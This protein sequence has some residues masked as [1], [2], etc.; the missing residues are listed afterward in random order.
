MGSTLSTKG[1]L[2]IPKEVREA[3]Q[4]A[5]GHEFEFEVRDEGVLIKPKAQKS[6]TVQQAFGALAHLARLKPATEDEMRQGVLKMA[7]ERQQRGRTK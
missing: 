1:Q 6:V 2:V 5:S 4:W 3:K 7:A